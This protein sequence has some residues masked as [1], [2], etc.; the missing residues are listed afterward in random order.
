MTLLW[1]FLD[2]VSAALFGGDFTFSGLLGF[3]PASFAGQ[4]VGHFVEGAPFDCK[5]NVGWLTDVQRIACGNAKISPT[6]VSGTSSVFVE[7]DPSHLFGEYRQYI[8]LNFGFPWP[9][10]S[11]DIPYGAV[12]IGER[13]RTAPMNF[14]NMN[15]SHEHKREWFGPNV[16]DYYPLRSFAFLQKMLVRW[17]LFNLDEIGDDY[18][19]GIWLADRRDNVIILD[20]TYDRNGITLPQDV[21]LSNKE[22]YYGVP[23]QSAFLSA[24]EPENPNH[25][26]EGEV[27]R[28]G[29]FTRDSFDNQGRFLGN[30]SRFNLSS[31]LR[32]EI[33]SFV[34][35]K[36]LV[37]TNVDEDTKPTRNIEPQKIVQENLAHYAQAKDFVLGL[38]RFYNFIRDG[39]SLN[40]PGRCNIGFGDPIYLELDEMLDETTNTLQNTVRVTAEKV[41]YSVS[42]PKKGPG[43]FKRTVHVATRLYP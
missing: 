19:M 5:H 6:D 15:Y 29:I 10:T 33:D 38:E 40:T 41:T 21:S 12:S 39:Y 17:G 3:D 27:V 37:V 24:D 32:L 18:K 2:D 11:N 35:T 13:I 34:M 1:H 25:F 23:G 30:R 7:Q 28:G 4:K 8:G 43:G 22:Y 31:Y 16:E 14:Y 9:R 20:Y 42:K 36:P 26:I